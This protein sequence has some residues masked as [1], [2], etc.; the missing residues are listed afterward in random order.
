MGVLAYKNALVLT[1]PPE[2]SDRV[3]DAQ[4]LLAGHN[5]FKENYHPGTLDK[6]MGKQTR[7]AIV[8][9]QT[10]LG[11][12]TNKITGAMG[13]TLFLYLTGKADLPL[14]YKVR[15]KKRLAEAA[16]VK[17]GKLA[18][19]EAARADAK[20]GIHESPAESNNNQYGIWYGFNRVAWCCE[21]VTYWLVVKGNN[22]FWQRGRFASYCGDV[23]SAARRGERHLAI[24]SQPEP[25]DGVI[26]EYDK[27]I[28][29]FVQ[30]IDQS[31]G[32][33]VAV[34]GNT[35]GH[36]GSYN[37]GGEVAENVRYVSGNFPVTHF[38]RIGF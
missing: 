5:V 26:Y 29:L 33:F 24:T 15:R 18:A 13:E 3:G 34:G 7:G 17:K 1:S 22:K 10:L 31:K 27:H 4:W 12:P 30:W 2:K 35:S 8:R 19:L 32:S 11:Y 25:G 38:I 14:V 6:Q 37:N 9:A 28:E 23:V 20:K 16:L 21:A 36:D